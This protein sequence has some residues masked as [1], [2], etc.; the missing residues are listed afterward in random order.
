MFACIYSQAFPDGVSLGDFAYS[1]SPLV[2][3]TAVDTV[4]IDTE[5]CELLFGSAYEL[6]NEIANRARKSKETG[7]LGCKVNV[8]LAENPDA[9]IQAARFFKGI[10]FIS[11]GEELTALG[12]L[13]VEALRLE[14][15]PK[16]KVQNPKSEGKTSMTNEQT[17]DPGPWT[18]DDKIRS[19]KVE[20]I[21][22]TLKLWGIQ[23][24]REFAALPVT[25]VSERLGQ[26]GVNLQQL[27]RGKTERSLKLK[28]AAPVFE[29][30]IE[31][32][33]PLAEL[34]PLSFIFARLLNQ[35]CASLN[36]YALATNEVRVLMRLED[37]TLHERKLN[38]PYPMRD[39]KGFL[40]LLLLDTEMHPPQSPV[41]GITIACEPV[42]PR[43]LQN[44]LFIPLSPQP[45]KL[46]LTLAR[47]AKLVGAENTGSPELV[48]TNR[49]DAFRLKRFV[50]KTTQGKKIRTGKKTAGPEKQFPLSV[51]SESLSVI[52]FRVFR[53]P[54]RAMVEANRG[55][56]T[57]I[58]AWGENRS[59]HGKVLRLGGPWRTTGD[60]WRGSS[61]ARDEWDVV[62][63]NRS[64]G[65]LT[66]RHK[67]PPLQVF[68]RIYR[69]LSSGTW[70]VEGI[71]D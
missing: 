9:A 47:L 35:L 16:S 42:K 1:F 44:G 6:A 38:L 24:F 10:T 56:P 66:G 69:E 26:E 52:G 67:D 68:Y 60:W 12:D 5:G 54:L 49:P 20:E 61:W 30:S 14:S 3:E 40:K 55:Y 39:H 45:E 8:A 11:S 62:V 33:H 34:E 71:Y 22:A 48:D 7:G 27:A 31:W 36:A 2:E 64:E 29:N 50:V 13:P 32:E 70:F 41:V 19:Q 18:L 23:T 51:S 17:L 4:V 46:E 57:Q 28:Q 63:E 25:G 43:V 21:L 15:S 59:V 37:Q 58:S 53:P 65:S